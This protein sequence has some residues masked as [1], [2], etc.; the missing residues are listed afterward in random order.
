MSIQTYSSTI[1]RKEMDAVLTCMVDEKTGPGELNARLV[2]QT[3][4]YFKVA[5]AVALRSPAL[6]LKYV[7]NEFTDALPNTVGA[8]FFAKRI[9]VGSNVVKLQ[10]WDT[11]GQERFHALTPLY[12]HGSVGAILVFDLSTP[13]SFKGVETWADEL[14]QNTSEEMVLAVVGSKSD[15]YYALPPDQRPTHAPKAAQEYAKQIG[16]LYMETSAKTG[17]GV[18]ELFIELTKRIIE[19]NLIKIPDPNTAVKQATEQKDNGGGIV[20]LDQD[21]VEGEKQPERKPR[22]RC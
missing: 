16:A 13:S 2:Q 19:R 22:R 8:C 10:I 3:K 4:D 6:A 21:I 1:R 5:G 9:V 15:K 18:E 7:R 11:A 14:S 20:R 12:Y 17:T